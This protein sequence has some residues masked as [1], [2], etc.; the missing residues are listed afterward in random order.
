VKV[1]GSANVYSVARSEAASVGT[2]PTNAASGYLQLRSFATFDHV[3]ALDA[4]GAT[5]TVSCIGAALG[6]FTEVSHTVDVAGITVTS[7][8][9]AADVVSVRFQNES[10]STLDLASGTLRVTVRK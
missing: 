1:V 4:V 2:A 7:W 5:T 10:G 6:D 3:S 9:S 8:V